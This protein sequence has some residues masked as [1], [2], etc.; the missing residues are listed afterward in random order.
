MAM[1]LAELSQLVGGDACGWAWTGKDGLQF[2][3]GGKL[4]T[5][6]GEG[7]WGAPPEGQAG[8]SL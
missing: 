8:R 7:V 5:P 6:W 2:L 4:K 1:Q 3:P